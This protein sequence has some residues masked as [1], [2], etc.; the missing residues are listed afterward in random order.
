MSCFLQE[1]LALKRASLGKSK[2]FS[3]SPFWAIRAEFLCEYAVKNGD[4]YLSYK[5]L[6]RMIL[7]ST[8]SSGH[9]EST[10]QCCQ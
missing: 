5:E 10:L 7:E 8:S 6:M 3:F 4:G 9:L 2:S 1:G